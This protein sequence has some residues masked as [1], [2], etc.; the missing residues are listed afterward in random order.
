MNPGQANV[1]VSDGRVKGLRGQWL[2]NYDYFLSLKY[3]YYSYNEMIDSYRIIC[4]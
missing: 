2:Y 3:V 1:L 4:E